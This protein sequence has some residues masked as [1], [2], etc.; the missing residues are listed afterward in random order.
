MLKKTMN[1]YKMR[2]TEAKIAKL[3]SD[4]LEGRTKELLHPKSRIAPPL[5]VRKYRKRFTRAFLLSSGVFILCLI[6]ISRFFAKYYETIPEEKT[7]G[8]VYLLYIVMILLTLSPYAIFGI[9]TFFKTDLA[10]FLFAEKHVNHFY[11]IMDHMI[12]I[13][14]HCTEMILIANNNVNLEYFMDKCSIAARKSLGSV[15]TFT[16]KMIGRRLYTMLKFSSRRY[17]SKKVDYYLT[18]INGAIIVSCKGRVP[19]YVLDIFEQVNANMIEL[20]KVEI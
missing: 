7:K 4:G 6:I 15:L 14:H 3:D 20:R 11:K 9:R 16:N 19:K 17:F 5:E 12:D 2:K 1:R 8:I 13:A 10:L 18:E